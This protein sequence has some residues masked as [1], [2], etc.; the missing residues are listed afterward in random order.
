[1]TVES[2]YRNF[3]VDDGDEEIDSQARHDSNN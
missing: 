2:I 3:F 1:M